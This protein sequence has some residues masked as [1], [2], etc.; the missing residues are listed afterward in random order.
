MKHHTP[1]S[2]ARDVPPQHA[3]KLRR[4][5]WV[6]FFAAAVVLSGLLRL[7]LSTDAVEVALPEPS[8]RDAVTEATVGLAFGH[9]AQRARPPRRLPQNSPTVR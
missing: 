6:T 4:G 3:G 7:A 9:L 8:P 5:A 2:T 1:P